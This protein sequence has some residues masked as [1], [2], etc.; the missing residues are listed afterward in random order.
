MKSIVLRYLRQTLRRFWWPALW[1]DLQKKQQLVEMSCREWAGDHTYLQELCR[2][3]GLTEQEVEGDSYGVPCVSALA[4][5]LSEALARCM[6]ERDQL[7]AE[8]AEVIHDET[9][10]N[11]CEV[12]HI[13]SRFSELHGQIDDLRAEVSKLRA[14][15]ANMTNEEILSEKLDTAYSKINQLERERDEAREERNAALCDRDAWARL[16][17]AV[18]CYTPSTAEPYEALKIQLDEARKK[19]EQSEI[20]RDEIYEAA[21]SENERH[22]ATALDRDE[23]R[24][25]VER[26]EAKTAAEYEAHKMTKCE[27]DA[28]KAEVERLKAEN[29][30][31]RNAQMCCESCDE[32]VTVEILR[33]LRADKARLDWLAALDCDS[34]LWG[35]LS[36][37]T[38]LRCTIDAAMKGAE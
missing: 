29:V 34:P 3:A 25:E 6:G 9:G 23:L 13:R 26:A 31:L 11:S 10:E 4:G 24:A 27:R 8:L 12:V 30:T 5:M 28:L 33:E 20:F 38:K 18:D 16:C 17:G 2:K 36:D 35:A 14:E 37:T 22:I 1:R 7:R 19:L 32:T 15:H 21:K